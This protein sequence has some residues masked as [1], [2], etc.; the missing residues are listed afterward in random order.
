M[1]ETERYGIITNSNVQSVCFG[2]LAQRERRCLTS[3]RPGVQIP[4]RPPL[5]QRPP[6]T[7]VF[8]VSGE[9]SL[10]LNP[11]RAKRPS[12]P[13]V[14]EQAEGRRRP[15]NPRSGCAQIPH[16]PPL[17]QRPPA[18]GGLFRFRGRFPGFEPRSK[19]SLCSKGGT[20]NE[21]FASRSRLDNASPSSRGNPLI[22]SSTVRLNLIPRTA[23]FSY[24]DF[25]S[26]RS[27]RL[28]GHLV[29]KTAPMCKIL[30]FGV[31]RSSKSMTIRQR[32][33]A[34]KFRDLG[35]CKRGAVM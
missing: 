23:S 34:S 17:T 24:R 33:I 7:G 21:A 8:F 29:G 20:G 11:A 31:G 28:E 3:T 25:W 1:H 14:V 9:A 35:F 10:D 26:L 30:L 18:M 6:A 27:G 16:R 2:R 5:T 32:D 4:H 19:V 22:Q 12:G 13:F 15:A